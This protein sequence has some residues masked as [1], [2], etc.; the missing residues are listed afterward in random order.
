MQQY[1]GYPK[2]NLVPRTQGITILWISNFNSGLTNFSVCESSPNKICCCSTIIIKPILCWTVRM[3]HHWIT[4]PAILQI[5]EWLTQL[6]AFYPAIFKH[7]NLSLYC[8]IFVAGKIYLIVLINQILL[9]YQ[10]MP[11]SLMTADIKNINNWLFNVC[12]WMVEWFHKQTLEFWQN[13]SH[14]EPSFLLRLWRVH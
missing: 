10:I 1:T 3:I 6:A 9:Y 7:K 5:F 13:K 2:T 12:W 8:E 11:V 14:D 4:C